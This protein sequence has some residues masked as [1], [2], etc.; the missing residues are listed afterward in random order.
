MMDLNRLGQSYDGTA[1]ILADDM[2]KSDNCKTTHGLIR[3]SNRYKILGVIDPCNA[4]HDAGVLLDGVKRDIEVYSSIEN[5][6]ETGQCV[7]DFCIVGIAT[8]GGKLTPAIKELMMI[9]IKHGISVVS[10]LHEYISSDETLVQA[11][12]EHKVELIDI[13]KSKPVEELAF[14]AAR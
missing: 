9:A 12:K 11:A 1:I 6:L 13:R 14:W 4:G 10:G 5:M 7:P 2:V 3:K 8:S